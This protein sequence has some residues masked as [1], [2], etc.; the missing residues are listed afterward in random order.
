MLNENSLCFKFGVLIGEIW[1]SHKTEGDEQQPF[2]SE[3]AESS[4]PLRGG[5]ESLYCAIIK[6]LWCDLRL[7]VCWYGSYVFLCNLLVSAHCQQPSVSCIPAHTTPTPGPVRHTAERC[8]ITTA[9]QL[10]PGCG[11]I[12]APA[13]PSFMGTAPGHAGEKQFRMKTCT[14][15][16]Q[17]REQLA[18]VA[19]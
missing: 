16:Q 9:S 2:Q 11:L 13:W 12:A 14:V 4:A 18:G 1:F 3:P 7:A 8:Y 5:H 19:A 15:V 10:H 6:C 17:L